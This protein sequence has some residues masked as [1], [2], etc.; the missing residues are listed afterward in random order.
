MCNQTATAAK[1]STKKFEWDGTIGSLRKAISDAS[2]QR[3][4]GYGI[5]ITNKV[6]KSDKK[7]NLRVWTSNVKMNDTLTQCIKN[8]F[9]KNFES[10]SEVDSET[11]FG[12]PCKHLV[13]TLKK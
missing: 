8:E 4:D 13:V 9:G 12:K 3:Y 2:K 11:R 1:Q 10:V 5:K 7:R 6:R